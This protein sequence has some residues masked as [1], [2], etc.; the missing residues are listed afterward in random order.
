MQEGEGHEKKKIYVN[1]LRQHDI[2]S[3]KGHNT[4]PYGLQCILE[5]DA[6]FKIYVWKIHFRN[7]SVY[8]MNYMS[9][10]FYKKKLRA[11]CYGSNSTRS[12]SSSTR[13]GS[14]STRSGS[15]FGYR[16]RKCW[17]WK[18]SK[19]FRLYLKIPKPIIKAI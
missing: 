7:F 8:W 2:K 14:N 11:G 6:L 16:I 13:P 12:G 5:T 9:V 10:I 17:G 18:L 1:N 3:C 19:L 4:K 15:R